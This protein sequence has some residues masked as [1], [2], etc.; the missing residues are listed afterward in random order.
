[1]AGYMEQNL[2]VNFPEK[3]AAGVGKQP[4][5]TASGAR[6][7]NLCEVPTAS[8]TEDKWWC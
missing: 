4:V 8:S 5:L 2:P 7:K 6:I 3:G 1:M